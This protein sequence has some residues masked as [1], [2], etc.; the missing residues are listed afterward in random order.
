M[1]VGPQG[2]K[3]GTGTAYKSLMV[4]RA[5]LRLIKPTAHVRAVRGVLVITATSY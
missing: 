3:H 1:A 5:L 4:S 2:D